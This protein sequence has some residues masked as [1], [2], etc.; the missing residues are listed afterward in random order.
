MNIKENIFTGNKLDEFKLTEL[1]DQDAIL[2]AFNYT[3]IGIIYLGYGNKVLCFNK[4]ILEILEVNLDD[5]EAPTFQNIIAF[6]RTRFK[7]AKDLEQFFALPIKNYF[8]S[9]ELVL[10]TNDGL[11]LFCTSQPILKNNLIEGVV[12]S[13]TDITEHK[14]QERI[15]TYRS[16]HDALTQLPNRTYLFQKLTKLTN[17]EYR[18]RKKFSLLF[19]DIDDLKRINDEYG[20]SIGDDFIKEF[21]MRV[22]YALRVPDTLARLS[23][24]EFVVILDNVDNQ[25]Q[26]ERVIGRIYKNLTSKLP[27]TEQGILATV[28]IGVTF[29]PKQGLN[30]RELIK[31]ADEAMYSAKRNGKN[32]FCFYKSTMKS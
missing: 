12:W 18:E 28:S 21:V 1:M 20:H 5:Y 9:Q 4:R 27:V 6:S 16:L 11:V 10:E 29:Y 23:G 25:V 14:I 26:V 24:D 3:S 32:T 13:V 30:P 15:A 19:L 7:N 2:K 31:Q 17:P 22:S 8:D